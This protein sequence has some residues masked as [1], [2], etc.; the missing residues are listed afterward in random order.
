MGILRLSTL[1]RAG[2][3]GSGS[4]RVDGKTGGGWSWDWLYAV[5]A[6]LWG[7]CGEDGYICMRAGENAPRVAVDTR[8]N[9]PRIKIYQTP[10]YLSRRS[11]RAAIVLL[12]PLPQKVLQLYSLISYILIFFFYK[13]IV[14]PGFAGGSESYCWKVALWGGRASARWVR[15]L[16]WLYMGGRWGL[17]VWVF[18]MIISMP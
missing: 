5:N 15:L 9:L 4:R 14:L 13:S 10:S 18:G 1:L 6:G 8:P 3:C 2:W 17:M 7:D 11:E 16:R 12:N